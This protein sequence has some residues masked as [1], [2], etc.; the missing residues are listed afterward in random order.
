M[1]AIPNPLI[2]LS[3]PLFINPRQK[4]EGGREGGKGSVME[5]KAGREVEGVGGEGC[6]TRQDGASW[7]RV[8]GGF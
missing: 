7:G 5:C 2:F 4:F 1:E 6:K 3:L 8:R